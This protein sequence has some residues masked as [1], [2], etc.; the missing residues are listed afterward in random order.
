MNNEMMLTL[1]EMQAA[2]P[3][4]CDSALSLVKQ[5]VHSFSFH[6]PSGSVM[7]YWAG[8]FGEESASL[9]TVPVWPPTHMEI[10]DEGEATDTPRKAAKRAARGA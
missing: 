8:P 1:K 3:R 7:A 5:E 2:A 9:G 10:A 6:V 4:W